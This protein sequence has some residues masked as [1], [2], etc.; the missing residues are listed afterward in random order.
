MWDKVSTTW[1]GMLRIGGALVL[2]EQGIEVIVFG[3]SLAEHPALV[4][5]ALGALGAPLPQAKKEEKEAT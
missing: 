4:I 3:T 5:A 2:L 1:P